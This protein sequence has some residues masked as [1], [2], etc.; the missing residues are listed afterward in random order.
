P[1]PAVPR[2]SGL[3]PRAPATSAPARASAT[4]IARPSPRL[5]PV[6]MAT[7]P[8]RREAASR[9]LP[10]EGIEWLPVLLGDDL[11]LHFESRSQ[12][13]VLHREVGRQNRE[14]LDLGVGLQLV[15]AL[16][17]DAVH[18]LHHLRVPGERRRLRIQ[19]A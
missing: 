14:L 11:P 10:V 6:T 9:S 15:V 7:R 18:P 16:L 19:D 5:A 13:P 12:E 8:S 2:G 4:A 17:H 3:E 1:R